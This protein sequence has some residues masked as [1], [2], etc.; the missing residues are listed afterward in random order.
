MKAGTRI[1]RRPVPEHGPWPDGVPEVLQ[2]ILAARGVRGPEDGELKLVRL[3]SPDLLGG[4]AAAARLLAEAIAG[5][6]HIVVVGDF[7]CDGATGTAVAVRGLRLLG[8]DHVSYQVP[9]RMIHGYGL[10]PALVRDIAV[11]QPDLLVTVDSGIACHAGVAAA[12]ACGWQ[13]LITDHHLAGAILPPADAIVNPNLAGDGFPSKALAGVGV[14][15]YL[16]LALRRHLREQGLFAAGEPDLSVLLDLV[17]IGTVADLVPLDFNNR[18]LVAAGLRRMRE[19]R[20]HPGVRALAEC[21]GRPLD[22]ITASDIGFAIGP[23]LNAAGRLDDMRIG[24]ECLLADDAA[25]ARSLAARLDGINRERRERQQAMVDDAE[26]LL[27]VMALA[28]DDPAPAVVLYD[29]GWHPGIVGLVASRIKDRLH[30]PTIAF[31]PAES[32]SALLRGSARSIPGFHI[33]DALAAVD[34][35]CPG[36]IE[37]FGGHAMAAGLS[38][39]ENRLAEFRTAFAAQAQAHLGPELL[40]AEC[41]SDGPLAPAQFDRDLAE[42]LR[43]AG[44]W[45]QAFPEPVFDN[46]FAVVEWRVLGGRHLKLA[47]RPAEGGPVLSAVQFGGW[48]GEAPPARM[49]VAYQLEPDDY[50]GRRAVQLLIRHWLPE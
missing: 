29:T 14:M 16:L 47:L 30:R 41:W 11:L 12:K 23:R 15:F 40:L 5:R 17:A 48:H 9:Q 1:V 39:P 2:R 28:E 31:A 13:V 43:L 22:A 27:G 50:R 8:A 42:Q 26:A 44:P 20:C 49:H 35:C 24:I 46:V 6:R 3:L 21:A 36:L 19:G 4:V 34:A 32:G 37:R 7:D 18:L 38:L 10:S 25:G 45:G 33:R